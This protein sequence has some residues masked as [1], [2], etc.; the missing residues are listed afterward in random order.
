M[1]GNPM[2][3]VQMMCFCLNF[4]IRRF[5]NQIVTLKLP[6]PPVLKRLKI[7]K[8]AEALGCEL[9]KSPDFVMLAKAYGG[10]GIQAT[11]EKPQRDRCDRMG[12]TKLGKLKILM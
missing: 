9:G 5:F 10:N 7:P 2:Y 8:L 6:S 3:Q 11:G 12:F 1:A 4:L